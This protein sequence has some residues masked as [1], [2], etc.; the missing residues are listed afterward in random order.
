M[1]GNKDMTKR[2]I[3]TYID[4]LRNRFARSGLS[5][6]KLCA[7]AGLGVN[8]LRHLSSPNFNPN[9]STLQ[10]IEDALDAAES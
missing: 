5:R 3:D 8:T 4:E 9:L 2:T 7:M 1:S 6:R 10:R